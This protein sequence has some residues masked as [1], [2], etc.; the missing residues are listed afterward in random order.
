LKYLAGHSDLIQGAVIGRD[1]AIFEPVAFL[2]N[3][4]GGTP[5]PFTAG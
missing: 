2:Q 3:A 1:A 4:L 5:S